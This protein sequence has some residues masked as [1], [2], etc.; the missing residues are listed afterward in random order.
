MA[1]KFTAISGPLGAAENP[2]ASL[3]EF[4]PSRRKVVAPQARV[5]LRCKRV[6]RQDRD[7][8]LERKMKKTPCMFLR[9]MSAI[10]ILLPTCL[11]GSAEYDS[12]ISRLAFAAQELK[13]V[14]RS[15]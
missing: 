6:E 8:G 13:S 1:L 5:R 14:Q 2:R 12:L 4:R 9:V 11:A 10:G 15:S 3:S 7:R